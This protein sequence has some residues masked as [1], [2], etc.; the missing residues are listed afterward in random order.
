[1]TQVFE[2]IKQY[3][4]LPGLMIDISQQDIDTQS[5]SSMNVSLMKH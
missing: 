4:E 1:M 3:F 5:L 2:E